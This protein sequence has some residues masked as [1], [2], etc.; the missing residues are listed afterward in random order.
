M[1]SRAKTRFGIRDY[2]LHEVSSYDADHLVFIDKSGF[3]KRCGFRRSGWSPQGVTPVRI[4]RFHRGQGYQI[5]PAYTL[6]SVP[7]LTCTPRFD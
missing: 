1:G 6:N 5:L 2:Y 4:A 7:N 3:E